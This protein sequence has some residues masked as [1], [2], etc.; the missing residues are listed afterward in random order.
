VASLVHQ[1]CAS[2]HRPDDIGPMSL[3]TYDE[4]RPWAKSMLRA[5]KAG[6]MP[7]W[8]AD[9][10]HGTFANDR[11]LEPREVALLERWVKQGARPGNLDAAPAPP[12]PEEGWRL[13]EPDLVLTF[14]QISL[15]AGGPDRFHDLVVETGLAEERWVRAIEIRPGNRKVVHHV[16]LYAT[17]GQGPPSSGWLGAWAAGMAPM[18]LP[19]GTAKLVG[20]GSR[21][22]ADMHY[23]PDAEAATDQTRVGLHFYPGEP[24]KELINLWVQ[25]SSFEI[26]AGAE[27]HVVR[28]SH[29]FRQDA[30]IHGLLPHMHYRG[31]EFTYTATFPDGRRQV[32]LHVPDYDFN[33]QTLYQLT[34]PLVVPA[35][36]RID[37]EAHYDNSTGNPA[38]PDPTRNVTFGN[39]SFDEMMIGFVDYTVNEGQRP[40]SVEDEIAAGLDRLAAQHPGET[41]S[42]TVTAPGEAMALPTALHVPRAGEGAWLIPLNGQVVEGR[43][44]EIAFDGDAFTATLTAPVGVFQVTGSL[45]SG[46]AAGTVTLGP[47]TLSFSGRPHGGR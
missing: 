21:I 6:E 3:L 33:W 12:V 2:C 18:E 11:R 34:E 31:K 29:T 14:D 38:N 22:V 43:L 32:L 16:I 27:D 7:P 24:E 42:V 47:Q 28:A 13:G 39:E 36:T 26:P 5:V 41:W 8:H 37:C 4:A 19:P 35:G 25:N 10:A 44:H 23:H 45:A 15:P 20:A 9:P 40:H 1:R 46:E 17:D 30:T